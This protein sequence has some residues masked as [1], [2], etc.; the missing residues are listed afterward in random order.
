[1]GERSGMRRGATARPKIGVCVRRAGG[2]WTDRST[3]LEPVYGIDRALR[4][5]SGGGAFTESCLVRFDDDG[6]E[7]WLPWPNPA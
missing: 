7:E 6:H 2:E 4:G 1:M 3:A 5:Y